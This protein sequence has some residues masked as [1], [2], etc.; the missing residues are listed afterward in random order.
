MDTEILQ[1]ISCRVDPFV[2]PPDACLHELLDGVR[3][4]V[5]FDLFVEWDVR[6]LNGMAGE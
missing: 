3:D 1:G 2:G 4:E 6:D 5:D